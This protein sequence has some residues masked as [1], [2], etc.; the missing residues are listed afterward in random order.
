MIKK[1]LSDL[2][3]FFHEIKSPLN[4]IIRLLRLME[5]SLVDRDRQKMKNYLNLLLSQAFYMKNLI[6]NTLEVGKIQIGKTDMSLLEFDLVELLQEVYEFTKI[7]V[8]DK[9][10]QIKLYSPVKTF[11][12]DSD[13]LKLKQILFN[14]T[15]NSAKFTKKGFITLELVTEDPIKIIIT[16]TGTGIKN[17]DSDKLFKPFF[18]DKSFYEKNFDSTGLGLYITKALL[19]ILNGDIFIESEYGKGTKVCIEIPKKFKK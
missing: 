16:D 9:P 2:L 7:L 1:E 15:S 18:S 11:L 8:A 5:L 17:L 13:P 14:I 12:I 3:I 4:G 19:N 10:V 6:D